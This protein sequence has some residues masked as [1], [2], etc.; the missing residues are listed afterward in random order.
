VR[1]SKEKKAREKQQRGKKKGGAYLYCTLRYFVARS[2][3]LESELDEEL[4]E[5]MQ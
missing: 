2:F 1:S 3:S 4:E 5:A